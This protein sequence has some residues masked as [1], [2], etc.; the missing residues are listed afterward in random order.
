MRTFDETLSDKSATSRDTSIQT[1]HSLSAGY[2]SCRCTIL[3]RRF[4][5]IAGLI[6]S[7]ALL[8]TES[9]S[10]T[11]RVCVKIYA[12]A[13]GKIL[14]LTRIARDAACPKG[15]K[16][17][18]NTAQLDTRTDTAI[19][20]K[21][22]NGA[23][24]CSCDAG[25]KATG[26]G[27][28]C[29]GNAIQSSLPDNMSSWVATCG[30]ATTPNIK[31]VCSRQ[32]CRKNSDCSGQSSCDSAGYCTCNSEYPGPQCQGVRL[33]G[34]ADERTGRV[35]VFHSGAWGTVCDDNFTETDANV[36]CRQLGY[37][38]GTAFTVG[39]GKESISMDEVACT[40]SE[41]RLQDCSFNGWGLT[42]CS[43]AE[44]VGV[45]CTP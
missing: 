36:V 32:S 27:V 15:Y 45:S 18:F 43:H 33:I 21:V 2:V 6:I 20:H 31:L 13:K 40:G 38:S 24:V 9:S 5:L 3:T 23:S 12:D 19:I 16:Q 10:A 1:E 8:T 26:A 37:S 39:G 14:S 35:E 25:G 42:D 28:D 41:A 22:C 4:F 11:D 17:L 29:S 44:D 30:A 7:S 34:G